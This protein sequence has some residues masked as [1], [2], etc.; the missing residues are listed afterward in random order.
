MVGLVYDK[1]E[2]LKKATF[3]FGNKILK[4]AIGG[5]EIK[6]AYIGYDDFTGRVALVI[7]GGGNDGTLLEQ[8]DRIQSP[9]IGLPDG[10]FKKLRRGN[11]HHPRNKGE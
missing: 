1:D 9:L 8:G 5:I 3:I 10:S 4:K 2:A 11:V 7:N 6:E